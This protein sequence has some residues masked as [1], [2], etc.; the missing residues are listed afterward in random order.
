MV[1]VVLESGRA[2]TVRRLEVFG[3]RDARRALIATGRQ[4]LI[5]RSGT[6][7]QPSRKP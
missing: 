2:L 1:G 4:R 5:C 6:S 7:D 3:V